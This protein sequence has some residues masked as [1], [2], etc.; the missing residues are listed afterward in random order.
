MKANTTNKKQQSAKKK[1]IPAIG[2]LAVSAVMLSTATYAWFTMNKEVEVTGLTMQAT[3]A[4]SIEIALASDTAD[5]FQIS[6]PGKDD[7]N[8]SQTVDVGEYY[9][10]VGK[11]KPAS[12][13]DVINLYKADDSMISAGGTVVADNATTVS[14]IGQNG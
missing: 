12:S 2:M 10:F 13:A 5:G 14:V 9:N 1:L 11:L 8:W 4:G 3:T 6:Q 7:S